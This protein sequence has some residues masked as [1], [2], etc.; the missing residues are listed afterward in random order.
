MSIKIAKAN[1][2]G[3]KPVITM[4]S[5]YG[6]TTGKE[7]MYRIPVLGERP[8][9]VQVKG[10]PEGLVFE[11]GTIRGIVP[12]DGEFTI[13]VTA[14]N[15]LGRDEKNV[16]LSSYPDNALR[17]PLLGFTTWNAF[18]W[19]LNQQMVVDIAKF[20]RDSGI[21]EY[22]YNYINLDSGWQKEYGGEFYAVIP[23]ED[24]FP[25]MKGFCDTMHEMGFKCGVYSSPM[26][27]AL[28]SPMTKKI[29]GAT[30]GERDIRF[31]PRRDGVGKEHYEGNN[32]RQ[33]DAWGFDYLK[34][35][36]SP[37]DT[38]LADLM[39]QE[40]LKAKRDI[41]FCVT[42]KADPGYYMYWQKNCCSFRCN[43]DSL[44]EWK[45]IK[46]RLQTTEPWEKLIIPGHFY[47]LDMLEIGVINKELF[48]EKLTDE[49]ELFSYTM[50]AFFLSPIQL[51]C[52][53]EKL[54]E[55]EMDMICNEEI[56]ALNQDALCD[57]PTKLCEYPGREAV[58]Y[59]R[60]LENG[61][62][63]ICVFNA[64]DVP[65]DEKIDLGENVKIRDL[66]TKEDL[67]TGD[68][69]KLTAEPHCVRVL[70]LSKI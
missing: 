37:T 16:L 2:F 43:R 60:K 38:Y 50:R 33:W 62:R 59:Q 11:N 23:E 15:S 6:V 34:Y 19:N 7:A 65:F 42:V 48:R 5:V 66:W 54:T 21:A 24:K 8:V 9:K 36:W 58:V 64:D 31:C 69:I 10:L 29:P 51:S 56:I 46:E 17:T 20:M 26:S 14:E 27:W 30:Q 13:T 44:Q 18:I 61:D 68:S 22:G 49:E 39:K 55:F 4:P 1:P 45:N 47:D 32:V 25:D 12:A 41:S 63:A 28:G 40:L 52:A 70:R 67:G 57:F 53:L 3:G 35:D